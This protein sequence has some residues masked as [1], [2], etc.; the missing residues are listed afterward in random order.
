MRIKNNRQGFTLIEL[1]I[2]V[3][4]VGI[5][6]AVA[7][8]LYNNYTLK[9]K[10]TNAIQNLLNLAS[11]QERFRQDAAAYASDLQLVKPP[12]YNYTYRVISNSASSYTLTATA[13]GNQAKDTACLVLTLTLA[14]GVMTTTPTDCWPK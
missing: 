7:I 12:D 2:V 3:I 6:A 1:M 14:S 10:R 4:I 13:Q 8:P 11:A 9:S 5:L